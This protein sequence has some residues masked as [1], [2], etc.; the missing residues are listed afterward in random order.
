[1][2]LFDLPAVIY[3]KTDYLYDTATDWL[4][5]YQN[6]TLLCYVRFLVKYCFDYKGECYADL[7]NKNKV[8]AKYILLTVDFPFQ[9]LSCDF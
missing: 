3:V 5:I 6:D 4:L 8:F 9:M 7:P 1:M 2:H